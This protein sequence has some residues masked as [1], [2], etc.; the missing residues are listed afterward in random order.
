MGFHT[1][2][3]T[4]SYISWNRLQRT[5]VDKTLIDL[6]QK[7]GDKLDNSMPLGG[8]ICQATAPIAH[9]CNFPHKAQ[10]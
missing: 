5:K 9:A 2:A 1:K 6:D 8:I 7:N 3:E 4:L 10:D